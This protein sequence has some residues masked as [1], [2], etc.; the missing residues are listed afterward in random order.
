MITKR[1]LKAEIEQLKQ[2]NATLKLLTKAYMRRTA[3]LEADIELLNASL[4]AVADE[5]EK[6]KR[7][8]HDI[9]E[10]RKQY[11]RANSKCTD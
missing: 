1:K 7:I 5:K 10:R 2:D 6:W 4:D 3:K 8:A 11:V 9:D